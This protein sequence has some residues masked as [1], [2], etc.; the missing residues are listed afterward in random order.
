MIAAVGHAAWTREEALEVVNAFKREHHEWVAAHREVNEA[1]RHLE[2]SEELF[3]ER[4]ERLLGATHDLQ[5]LI[6]DLGVQPISYG[7]PPV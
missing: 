3:R 2:H 1:K 4:S 6:A 5:L 7:G